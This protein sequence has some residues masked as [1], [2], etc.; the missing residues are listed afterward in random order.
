MKPLVPQSNV[1]YSKHDDGVLFVKASIL[2]LQDIQDREWEPYDPYSNDWTSDHTE[3]F[4]MLPSKACYIHVTLEDISTI[5]SL[6]DE[7]LHD[8]LGDVGVEKEKEDHDSR[9][10]VPEVSHTEPLALDNCQYLP[11]EEGAD[12]EDDREGAHDH[13]LDAEVSEVHR[14]SLD[15]DHASSIDEVGW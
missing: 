12:A 4:G 15:L 9:D 5:K 3:Q 7:K 14:G 10:C 8:S 13:D 6:A 1:E 2:S 11:D